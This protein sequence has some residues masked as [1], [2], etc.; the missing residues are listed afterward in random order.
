MLVEFLAQETEKVIEI[1]MPDCE[2]KDEEI[3]E[4]DT[5]S[6]AV[7][8]SDPKPIG[9]KLHKRARCIVN[10]EHVDDEEVRRAE[11]EHRKMLDYFLS[12]QE[13]TWA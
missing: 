8:L 9:H 5:V 13:I 3:E 10:I 2:Q 12:E 11:E 4:A 7:V 6:F 1:D